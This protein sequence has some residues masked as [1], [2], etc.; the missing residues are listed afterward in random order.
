MAGL[1]QAGRRSAIIVGG[2]MG[3]L[4]TGLLL[5]RA[6]WRVDVY[7]RI[8]SELSGR[9]AGIVTHQVLFDVLERAGVGADPDVLGV[10]VPGRRVFS[11]DGAVAGELR[12]PQVL[13]SWSRLYALLRAALPDAAYHHGKDFQRFE[14]TGRGVVARFADGSHAE[15]DLLV[16]AD[17]LFSAVRRQFLPQVGPKYAGYVAWRGLVEEA[18]LSASTRNSLCD[19]F[20]FSLP[21]GEQMLGYPVAGADE[22]LAP[23]KRRFNFVWYRPAEAGGGLRE[24]LTDTDGMQHEL[25][26]P[27]TKI[28]PAVMDSMRA[29]ADRLL[30]PQ[31]A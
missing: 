17:G 9:G 18:E 1:S 15:A 30:A 20:G 26:I 23:G 24:L 4:L 8:G 31:F 2:S 3:G 10:A 5:H 13:T 6:G 29:D 12:L 7:E 19:W 22:A 11:S 27:P 25:S 21:P 14:E 28:R 16:G